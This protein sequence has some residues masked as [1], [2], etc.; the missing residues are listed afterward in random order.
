MK[1][2]I[3][4]EQLLSRRE[5]ITFFFSKDKNNLL[6]QSFNFIQNL[7][8]KYMHQIYEK[9]DERIYFSLNSKF[10]KKICLKA[11]IDNNM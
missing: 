11:D 2:L 8:S 7:L 9:K 10:F 3:S 6:K 1:G 4:T 5:N